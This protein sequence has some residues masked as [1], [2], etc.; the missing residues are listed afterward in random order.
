VH[1]QHREPGQPERLPQAI[2]ELLVRHPWPGNV[3][4]LVSVMQVALALAGTGPITLEHLPSGFLAESRGPAAMSV[5]LPEDDL[6]TR[7]QNAKGNL[8][9]VARELGISRTTLY[10]RLREQ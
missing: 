4:E 9:A 5:A 2:L 10:K 8:S 7:L 3:R 6:Q 1:A